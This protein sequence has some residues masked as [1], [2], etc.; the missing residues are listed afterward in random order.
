HVPAEFPPED[1]IRTLLSRR[2][3]NLVRRANADAANTEVPD[4]YAS[5]VGSL[6][7]KTVAELS[8]FE[9]RCIDKRQPALIKT[10]LRFWDP[11][12]LELTSVVHRSTRTSST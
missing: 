4:E 1:D 9:V 3:Y 2:I 5:E 7:R 12:K 6:L 8:R 11:A 10:M